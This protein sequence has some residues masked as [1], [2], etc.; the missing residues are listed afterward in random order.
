MK[1]Y[2]RRRLSNSSLWLEKLVSKAKQPLT[3]KN[4]AIATLWH[5]YWRKLTY[6]R[7]GKPKAEFF[8]VIGKKVFTWVFL[9][10]IHSH[11]YLRNLLPFPPPP[12]ELKWFETDL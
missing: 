6:D 2:L 8:N 11:L 5:V 7:E 4:V 1:S 3:P 12:L 9:L 10:A